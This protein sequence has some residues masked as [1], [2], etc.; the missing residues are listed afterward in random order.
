MRYLYSLLFLCCL[1]FAVLVFLGNGAAVNCQTPPTA[2]S[3]DAGDIDRPTLIKVDT[4]MVESLPI[5]TNLLN[6]I[7][8]L[9]YVSKE[10][11][12]GND[13]QVR[14]RLD[15]ANNARLLVEREGGAI[16]SKIRINDRDLVAK[17]SSALEREAR[18]R[19]IRSLENES[20]NSTVRIEIRLVPLKVRQVATGVV[21]ARRIQ[22]RPNI[23]SGLPVT[24]FAAGSTA[25]SFNHLLRRRFTCP[26]G[27]SM[28][29]S[30]STDIAFLKFVGLGCCIAL[31]FAYTN[32]HRRKKYVSPFLV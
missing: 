27:E 30:Q 19:M 31:T 18:W 29:Y 24:A 3:R 15:V 9:R 23:K 6:K 20:R 26:M 16:I 25:R 11:I 1:M 4:S 21:L 8:Q 5:G 17:V 14:L 7:H 12:D 22:P 10:P 2:P 28:C 32:F 13:W